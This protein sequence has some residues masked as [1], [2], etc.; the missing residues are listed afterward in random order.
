MLFVCLVEIMIN[1]KQKKFHSKRLFL[2][3]LTALY[4]IT[5][6]TNNNNKLI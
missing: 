1:K 6:Y 4:I 2:N 5:K 3:K